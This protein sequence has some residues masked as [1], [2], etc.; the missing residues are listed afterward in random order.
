MRYINLRFTLHYI[1]SLIILSERKLTFTFAKC[2]RLS[3]VCRLSSV[4]NVR[5]SY[6]EDLN[7][8]LCYYAIWY[9]GHL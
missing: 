4:C 9:L 8:R 1:L 2:R 7:F 6:L 5:A 3:V